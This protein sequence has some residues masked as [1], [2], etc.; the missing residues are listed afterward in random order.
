MFGKHPA[1]DKAL[2]K[3]LLNDAGLGVKQVQ[4]EGTLAL[5]PTTL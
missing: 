2:E 3:G 5:P 1:K 4:W